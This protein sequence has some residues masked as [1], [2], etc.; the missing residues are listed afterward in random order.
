V[1]ID[2]FYTLR[3]TYY[4]KNVKTPDANA[5]LFPIASIVITRNTAQKLSARGF[6]MRSGANDGETKRNKIL[7]SSSKRLNGFRNPAQR[8]KINPRITPRKR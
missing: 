6:G 3:E 2:W 1:Y 8:P 4:E 7:N 5:F